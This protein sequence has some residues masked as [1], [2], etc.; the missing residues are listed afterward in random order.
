MMQAKNKDGLTRLQV[1]ARS[2]GR[3]VTQEPSLT[4]VVPA[5]ASFATPF[6][7]QDNLGGKLAFGAVM[8]E[9]GGLAFVESLTLVDRANQKSAMLLLLFSADPSGSTLT[10]NAATVIADADDVNLVAAIPIAIADYTTVGAKAV[11]NLKS[12][13][14][15]I[16]SGTQSLWGALVCLGTPTYAAATSLQ[17]TLG[18]ALT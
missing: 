18:L 14:I 13:H 4:L 12:L 9:T 10:D 16:K 8:T 15:P 5:M 1:L 3:L 7:A 17:L 2:N 11:A 6:S